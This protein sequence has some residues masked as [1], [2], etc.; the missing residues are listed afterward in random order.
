MELMTL[1]TNKTVI[2]VILVFEGEQVLTLF[3][4]LALRY[5]ER[6]RVGSAAFT[7]SPSSSLHSNCNVKRIWLKTETTNSQ[8]DKFIG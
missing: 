5:T 4:T 2:D 8:S 3:G 7:K 6:A 1:W